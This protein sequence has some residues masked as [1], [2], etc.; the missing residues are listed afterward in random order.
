MAG[1]RH[2]QL[3]EEQQPPISPVATTR[4]RLYPAGC[5]KSAAFSRITR[6]AVDS[7]RYRG[8]H[9]ALQVVV[10]S[11]Q[12]PARGVALARPREHQ[13]WSAGPSPRIGVV[14]AAPR[15]SAAV[16]TLVACR[17][18]GRRF[19]GWP[20]P[21]CACGGGVGVRRLDWPMSAGPLRSCEWSASGRR[22]C[23]VRTGIAVT[24]NPA[25]GARPA[26]IRPW[27]CAA[28]GER[29][30]AGEG[31][32]GRWAGVDCPGNVGDSVGGTFPH[33]LPAGGMV[34]FPWSGR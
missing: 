1:L 16:T 32:H 30:G 18:V 4:G 26:T 3:D 27:G 2:P 14:S 9:A 11:Q 28:R 12:V 22:R 23:S 5:W 24:R 34:T 31:A 29:R 19:I 8:S 13:A 20:A 17:R 25:T 6:V 21:F 33:R 15:G 10:R 7:F